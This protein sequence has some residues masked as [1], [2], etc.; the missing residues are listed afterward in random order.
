MTDK[1][2]AIELKKSGYSLKEI[3]KDLSR[4]K[5]TIHYWL[6]G[7]GI[8]NKPLLIPQERRRLASEALLKKYALLREEAY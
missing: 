1:E 4:N 6:K 5:S 7:L 2:K 8:S 3:S